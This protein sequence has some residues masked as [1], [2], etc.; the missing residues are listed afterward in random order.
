MTSSG[1]IECQYWI[2]FIVV[3]CMLTFSLSQ[4]DLNQFVGMTR[5]SHSDS[6]SLG[7]PEPLKMYN[8][9]SERL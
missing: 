8:F 9:P 6:G 3:E 4:P 1:H 7:H 2:A 5:L